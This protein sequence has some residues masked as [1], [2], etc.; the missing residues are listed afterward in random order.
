MK[1]LRLFA[2]ATAIAV[3]GCLSTDTGNLSR[4]RRNGVANV[5]L[6][7][8][9][10]ILGQVAVTT[11][12]NAAS[13]EMSGGKVD[14]QAS[15]SQAAWQQAPSI[16][17]SQDLADVLAAATLNHIPNTVAAAAAS[18]QVAQSAGVP[19]RDAVNA[20]ASTISGNSLIV[21]PTIVP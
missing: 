9:A 3:A 14:W 4:D 2:L 13:Q 17:T 15:A 19:T 16:V 5:L 10:K 1:T 7:K 12:A 6:T 21:R 11:L 8:A 20:I 18:L